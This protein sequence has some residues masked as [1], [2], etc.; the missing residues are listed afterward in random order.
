MKV[1][2][3]TSLALTA[4]VAM[5][6][7]LV[8]SASA[9]NR[10]RTNSNAVDKCHSFTPGAANTI[11]NR[12]VGA[13]NIGSA[14]IAVACV[15]ELTEDYDKDSAVVDDVTLY[16][17]NADGRDP[18]DVTCTLLPGSWVFGL[19]TALSQSVNVAGGA[20]ESIQF[21]GPWTSYGFGMNCNL[22]PLVTIAHSVLRFR[23]GTPGP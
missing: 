19:Q 17:R 12:V 7:G 8:S 22:P 4:A 21:T 15:F 5:S 2:V 11:R 9:E 1:P 16:F 6:V 23:N 14:T 18:V 10:H 13:E 20:V 3:I